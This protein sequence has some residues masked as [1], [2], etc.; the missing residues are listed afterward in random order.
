MSLTNKIVANIKKTDADVNTFVNTTNVVCIDTSNNR[1]GINRATLPTGTLD[2]STASASTK[3]LIVRGSTSQTAN[4]LELQDVNANI[5]FAVSPVG[6][7]YQNLNECV[8]FGNGMSATGNRQYNVVVGHRQTVAPVG[9]ESVVGTGNIEIGW[10]AFAY[11]PVVG[12]YNTLIGHDVSNNYEYNNTA[13]RSSGNLAYNVAIG[14]GA[15]TRYQDPNRIG[16]VFIG[17]SPFG[18]NYG[19][20]SWGSGSYNIAIGQSMMGWVPSG[21]IGQAGSNSIEIC[22]QASNNMLRYG[23][24][25]TAIFSNKLNIESTIVGDTTSKRIYIGNS[26]TSGTL[27]PDSTLQI[28]PKNATDKVLIVQATTAQTANLFEVQNSFLS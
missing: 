18:G 14:N 4:I 20:G 7:A 9:A 22:T 11:G 1:I 28:V 2:I 26:N 3:G 16:N 12:Q 19:V 21:W 24:N 10:R 6:I 5:G 15:N 8:I 23:G 13:G 25:F 17:G 27:S